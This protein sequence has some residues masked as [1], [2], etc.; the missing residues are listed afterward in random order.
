[1]RILSACT[2]SG[3]AHREV[4]LRT[5][6]VAPC[7]A[8]RLGGW[9]ARHDG[10]WLRNAGCID[11]PL[12]KIEFQGMKRAALNETISMGQRDSKDTVEI[13]TG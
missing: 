10:C 13:V 8:A 11:L 6:Q 5:L 7:T 12:E 4:S 9:I 3:H 2:C 1:M